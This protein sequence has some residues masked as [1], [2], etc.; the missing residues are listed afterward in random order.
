MYDALV[1]TIV[2]TTFLIFILG[3]YQ[4]HLDKEKDIQNELN[5]INEVRYE[6]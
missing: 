5:Q 2:L 1:S 4:V 3:V 6:I